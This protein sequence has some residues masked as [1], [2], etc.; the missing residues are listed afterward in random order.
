M[1]TIHTL[2]AKKTARVGVL[3]NPNQ[4]GEVVVALHGYGQLLPYFMRHFEPLVTQERSFIVPEGLNRFYVEGTSGR[5]GA[6]WMTREERLADIADNH[7]YLDE[8]VAAYAGSLD[9]RKLTV[10]AFSQGVATACRWLAHR[11][12]AQRAIFWAGSLPPD[13]AWP[14][15]ATVFGKMET[16][17][18]VGTDDPYFPQADLSPLTGFLDE[19]GASYTLNHFEGGHKLHAPL[20]TNLFQP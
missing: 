11:G 19:S 15:L 9:G 14:A 4:A 7:R 16:H 18:V 12:G 8:V 20:L 1:N 6:N 3:G 13:V 2:L 10:F 5:V 17:V